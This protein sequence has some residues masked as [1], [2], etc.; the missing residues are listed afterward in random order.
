MPERN[1]EAD[2]KE[3]DANAAAVVANDPASRRFRDSQNESDEPPL[4]AFYERP[5][6]I[7]ATAVAL[8][9]LIGGGVLYYLYARQ[10]ES[11]DDAFIAGRVTQINPEVSGYVAALHVDDNEFV[12]AGSLTP[13]LT[14]SCRRMSTASNG[15]PG[16]NSACSHPKTQPATT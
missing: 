3:R 9:I 14:A 13:F 1:H 15:K 11:T 16:R 12:E 2:G 10:Y 7:I 8:L 4:V 6:V 5:A